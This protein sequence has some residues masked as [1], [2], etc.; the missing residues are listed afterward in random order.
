MDP[1]VLKEAFTNIE[2]LA[3]TLNWKPFRP[4]V[5]MAQIY[6]TGGEGASAAFLRY[7][8]GASVPY[9][10]H[11]GYEHIFILSGSQTDRV[12]RNGQGTVIINPP[13]SEHHVTSTDGC[14]VLVI[15][16]K[17]VVVLEESYGVESSDR[18]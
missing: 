8:P 12:G 2:A 3:K 6:S 9:H 13:G 10:T 7:Q 18:K 4:G 16:E 15:W 17:P 11:K 1:I 14:I 5:E